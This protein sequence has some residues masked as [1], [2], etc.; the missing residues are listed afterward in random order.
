MSYDGIEVDML[1]LGN[2]DSILVTQ[3]SAG[4]ASRILIDGGNI[5][6]TEKVLAF[7]RSRGIKYLNH[8]VCSHPHDDHVGGLLG[9]VKSPN[10]DFGQAW[11]HLP[12]K[13]IDQNTLKITL[14]RVETVAKRVVTIIRASVQSSQDL[15]NAII[16]RGKPVTEPFQG[17]RIGFLFVC[18]PSLRFYEQL[19]KDFTDFEKLKAMEQS[20]VAHDA[21]NLVEALFETTA[22]AK[23]A[24]AAE[25]GLGKAPTEPENNSSTILYAK[26]AEDVCIFTADAGVEALAEARQAYKLESLSWMQIPHHGSRRNVNE[27]LISYFRPKTT[28]VSADGTK[29]HPRRAVVNAF[30]AVGTRVFSTHYPPPNGGNKWFSLGTVPERSDYSPAIPLYE[31]EK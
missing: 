24:E 16:A 30:K 18:G 1:N 5:S 8:I 3:W 14:N 19:L 11:V 4:V 13:H 9:V 15:V 7:L 6:D 26:H 17:M 2:A 12:W 20:M 10:I 23:Q 27:D 28:F 29:K 21:Q 22:F 31:A 25:S